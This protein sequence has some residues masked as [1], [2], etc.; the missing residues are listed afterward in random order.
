M[1]TQCR[2]GCGLCGNTLT[3]VMGCPKLNHTENGVTQRVLEGL[4]PTGWLQI[5]L[6]SNIIS[7]KAVDARWRFCFVLTSV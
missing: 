7:V 1:N 3:G 4:T 5:Y 6:T 2:G